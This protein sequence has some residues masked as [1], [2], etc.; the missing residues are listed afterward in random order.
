MSNA[1][2]PPLRR[3]AVGGGDVARKRLEALQLERL[4]WT[5][6]HA[7]ERVPPLPRRV[8]RRGIAPADIVTLEDIARLPFTGKAELALRPI[9]FGMFAVPLA[10]IRRIH[11]VG[12]DGLPHGRRAQWPT[13]SG[14]VLV[15]RSLHAAGV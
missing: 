8:R 2:R 14:G 7:Y 3:A 1:N 11:V 13:W 9:L 6:H 4:R 5:L 12:H 10:D 15:A